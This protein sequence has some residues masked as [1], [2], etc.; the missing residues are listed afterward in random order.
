MIWFLIFIFSCYAILIISLSIGFRK[1]KT[2]ASENTIPK[3]KFSVVIPFRNE[4]EKLPF[5]LKTIEELN[6]PKVF[7]EIIFV[8][9]SSEDNSVEIIENSICSNLNFSI[10]NNNRTS[11]SPKKDAI[12]SAISIAKNNW[13][14]T[15][16]ADC[17]LPKNWLQVLDNFIQQNNTKMIVAP[18]NYKAK[19]SFLHRFQLL[20]FM[21][22]QGTTIGGFGLDFKFMC[23]GANLA[24]K[25]EDFI[26]L[27][28]FEGNNN[29]ASGDDVFLLEKFVKSDKNSVCFLKSKNVIVS[30]FPVGSWKD[31]I[32]QRV[33]WASKTGNFKSV[34]VKLIGL[35]ILLINAS[36]LFSF[37]GC[38]MK[39]S[40]YTLFLILF[41]SKSLID[42]F[43]FLPT[44]K[45]FEQEKSFWES[46]LLS[47]FLYPFFS[48]WVIF[49]SVFF[50]YDWKGRSFKK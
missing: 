33:R 46:Y 45:F 21:S 19:N 11:N 37:F 49:K 26:Q 48:I 7:F 30:T 36:I 17:L 4:A 2:F 3:T 16:D 40:S 44:I 32:N 42:L 39:Q 18:V 47:S 5:S 1:V 8:D 22:M 12:T 25:K 35:L 27:N 24:Y 15:T 29:I 38:L 28:G 31:L 41:A 23:N 14:V 10:I 43:L 9:D 13:I 50:K 20:D 6:Y 34:K